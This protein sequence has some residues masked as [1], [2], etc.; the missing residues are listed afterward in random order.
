MDLGGGITTTSTNFM[1]YEAGGII[2]NQPIHTENM[3]DELDD[4]FGAIDGESEEEQVEVKKSK[5]DD[6]ENDTADKAV[7]RLVWRDRL[8][9]KDACPSLGDRPCL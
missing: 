6:A 3:A 4:L 2:L 5:T 9:K 7:A 8:V 1:E